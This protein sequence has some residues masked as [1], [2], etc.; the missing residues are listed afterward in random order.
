MKGKY[1]VFRCVEVILYTVL[2]FVLA[3]IIMHLI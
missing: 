3:A 2:S 1:E